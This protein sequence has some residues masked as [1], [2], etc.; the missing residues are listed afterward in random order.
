VLTLDPGIEQTLMAGLRSAEAGGEIE[1]E[2]KYAE[3]L[4]SFTRAVGARGAPYADLVDGGDSE[5]GEFEGFG[6]VLRERR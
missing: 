2:P 5:F 3:Q 6:G 4:L 1:V